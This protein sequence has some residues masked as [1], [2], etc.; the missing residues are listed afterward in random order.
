MAISTW[1]TL[2][3]VEN[4]FAVMK[5]TIITVNTALAPKDH[6]AVSRFQFYQTSTLCPQPNEFIASQRYRGV[7]RFD[8]LRLSISFPIVAQLNSR[9]SRTE[10]S[11]TYTWLYI[12]VVVIERCL[13]YIYNNIAGGGAWRNMMSWWR[14]KRDSNGRDW[15]KR[16]CVC[17]TLCSNAASSSQNPYS[18]CSSIVLKNRKAAVSHAQLRREGGR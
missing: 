1:Q 17:T 18:F 7:C 9:P 4:D 2:H 10:Q 15:S 16:C 5:N 8:T 6:S 3:A 12:P 13:G 11:R 14:N